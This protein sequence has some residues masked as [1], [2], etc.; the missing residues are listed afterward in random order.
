MKT[1]QSSHTINSIAKQLGFNAACWLAINTM[2][3]D[4][5]PESYTRVRE[6]KMIK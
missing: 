3:N 1:S 5:T 4:R 2:G 6:G